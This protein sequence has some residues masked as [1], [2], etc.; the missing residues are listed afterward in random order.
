MHE[1]SE[2][3]PAAPGTTASAPAHAFRFLM[4]PE[5]H[6]SMRRSRK[7]A[8]DRI[9]TGCEGGM[10]HSFHRPAARELVGNAR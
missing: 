5:I 7:R 2:H 10:R 4:Q 8:P 9:G 6:L 1:S 3:D